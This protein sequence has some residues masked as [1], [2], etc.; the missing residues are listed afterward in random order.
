MHKTIVLLIILLL[1]ASTCAFFYG[2]SGGIDPEI[3]ID[4]DHFICNLLN[5][6]IHSGYHLGTHQM[7]GITVTASGYIVVYSTIPDIDGAVFY[8]YADSESL[9]RIALLKSIEK[10]KINRPNIK[11]T[12]AS[13]SSG[14]GVGPIAV[15]DIVDAAVI[16]GGATAAYAFFSAA[17][18]AMP[19]LGF[20]GRY[21]YV[22]E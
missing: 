15:T 17:A 20:T 3:Q 18:G 12:N 2:C 19:S 8:A 7:N 16:A 10:I 13:T 9:A 4:D 11:K 21:E 6:N 14:F 22:T 5:D 1:L